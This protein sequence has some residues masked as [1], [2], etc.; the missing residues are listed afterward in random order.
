MEDSLKLPTPTGT[1]NRVAWALRIRAEKLTDATDA[2]VAVVSQIADAL[3]WINHRSYLLRGSLGLMRYAEHQLAGTPLPYVAVCRDGVTPIPEIK[4][5]V[6]TTKQIRAAES[7]AREKLQQ[8]N[9]DDALLLA[10][11]N[12][13]PFWLGHRNTSIRGRYG[14][15]HF[16]RLWLSGTPLVIT[17]K[18]PKAI[19]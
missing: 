1:S 8:A 6:G 16:A 5:M 15:I 3:W 13:A 14:I 4:E 18:P 11:V 9:P 19:A 17:P 2:E 10:T 12:S 7:I